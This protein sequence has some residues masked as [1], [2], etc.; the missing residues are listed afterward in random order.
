[1]RALVGISVVAL[2]MCSTPL[3]AQGA[4]TIYTNATVITVDDD[5]SI[6]E[7]VAVENGL[8][9]AVGSAEEM[10]ALADSETEIVDLGGLPLLPGFFDNHAHLGGPLQ[11]WKYGGWISE[12]PE[13]TRGVNTIPELL[14]AL[15]EKAANTPD[16]EWIVGAIS[17]EEWHNGSLPGRLDFDAVAPNNPV[18]IDRG[19]HT[20]LVN[21]LAF[22]IAG[23]TSET[24]AEGGE[25]VVGPDGELTGKVLE[26]ARRMIY[27]VMPPEA[28][29]T[30]SDDEERLAEWRMLL[31]QLVDLGITSVNVA[32]I[33]P[34]QLPLVEELYNRWGDEFPRATIQLRL[35][36]GHDHHA[37][38]EFGTMQ[39]IAELE[40]IGDRR[41]V[42][43]HPKLSMGAVK[44]SI[45]GGL[46]APIM[47]TTA[48]YESRPGFHG[49]QRIPDSVFYRVALRA[50][51]LGWQLG[52]HTM[53]DGAVD[54]VVDQLERIYEEVPDHIERDYLHHVAVR[55]S[56]ETMRQMGDLGIN[57]AS[58]PGFLL[59]LGSYADEALH[60]V[61]EAHQDPSRS[62]MN[63]GIRVSYGSDAGPYGPI[64]A[65][66]AGVTRR[67]WNDVVHG[68]S[69]AV[70]VGEA[71]RMH[72]YEP[73]YFTFREGAQ[74]TIEPGKVADLVVLSA[75]PFEVDPVRIQDIV[76]ERTIVGGDELYIRSE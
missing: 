64:S 18:A 5:S 37:D 31:N 4:D 45:D 62:L 8:I 17:R 76:V 12:L 29:D 58:Q 70:T 67:G 23:I 2:A 48:P 52:I 61:D 33:R 6:A 71:I 35:W 49:E 53:G 50:K 28:L 47:W 69:E 43:T 73:A 72:T 59:S 55:P 20:L 46:S 65:L 66:Y 38:V 13:W 74:G 11:P 40:A 21:S 9:L 27:D 7:A 22:E 60:P 30:V 57:V 3:A 36:P 56:D 41:A 32:G 44:M 51:Q 39:S 15:A 68:A 24:E 75:N 25:F 54:M 26:S 14:E 63:H 1:M 34:E 42:F 19:P 16:G 10:A